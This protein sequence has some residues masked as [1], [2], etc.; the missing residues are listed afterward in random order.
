M[1]TVYGLG[2]PASEWELFCLHEHFAR[3]VIERWS[4][5]KVLC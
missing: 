4:Y 3:G 2:I 5:M 1:R